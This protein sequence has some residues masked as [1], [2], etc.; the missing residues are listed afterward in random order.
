MTN[1]YVMSGEVIDFPAASAVANN[2]VILIGARIGVALAA[3]AA[4]AV[5]AVAVAGIF[6]ISK[7]S[8]DVVTIGALLYWDNANS[9]LTTTASGNTLAGFAAKAAGSGVTTVEISI[10]A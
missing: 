4:G 10:N 1:R 5:G 9:R 2:A 3:I 7:L 6:T 8:T